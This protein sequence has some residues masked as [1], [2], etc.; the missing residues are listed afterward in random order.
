MKAVIIGGSIAGSA[1]ALA[2]ARGGVDVVVLEADGTDLPS[3]VSDHALWL[4][5]GTPHGRQAHAFLGLFVKTMREF[6]PDVIED[7]ERVGV[8]VRGPDE[9]IPPSLRG[10]LPDD[11]DND[12]VV[13]NSRRS[14]VEAVMR[15]AVLAEPRVQVRSGVGVAGLE[16]KQLDGVPAVTG[17]RTAT[18]ELIEAD[19]VLDASGR[20]TGVESWL[21]AIGARPPSFVAAPTHQLYFTRHYQLRKTNDLSTNGLSTNDLPPLNSGFVTG[22]QFPWFASLMFPG[23]NGILQVVVGALPEDRPMKKVRDPEAFHAVTQMAPAVAPWVDPNIS[24]PVTDVGAMG[25]LQ[26]YVRRLV[27]DGEPVVTGIHLIGD[28]A[29]ITNPQYGRGVSHAVGHSTAVVK[30]VLDLAQSPKEQARAVDAE[31]QRMLV[32]SFEN[33]VQLDRNRTV[34]WQA[35]MRGEPPPTPVPGT[36]APFTQK[37]VLVASMN[38]GVVYRALFRCGML[39]DPPGSWK[40]NE[41]VVQRI[42]ETSTETGTAEAE[43]PSRDE[44][45]AAIS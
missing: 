17:V 23:D 32:P 16:A 8:I 27:V 36:D 12:L 40:H 5:P 20:K 44:V 31:V 13:I 38:D 7:I 11:S 2:L 33:A 10:E 39:L 24:V 26:N 43:L 21:S 28:A 9:L 19:V 3:D 34:L 6:A 15:R 29:A 30:T 45:L 14:L 22:T 35:G 25:N 37:Q 41:Q 4:R 18:G 1:A 42:V